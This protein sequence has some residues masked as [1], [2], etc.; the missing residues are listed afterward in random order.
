MGIQ[1]NKEFKRKKK[2]NKIK[3]KTKKQKTRK[4]G[5]NQHST[6]TFINLNNKKKQIY[7]GYLKQNNN[8]KNR[9]KVFLARP[10][11]TNT[12]PHSCVMARCYHSLVSIKLIIFAVSVGQLSLGLNQQGGAGITASCAIGEE[13]GK[14]ETERG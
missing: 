8:P 13:E 12:A 2:N 5:T 3:R 6:L 1:T 4:L 11:R 10:P 9:K 14:R 7:V